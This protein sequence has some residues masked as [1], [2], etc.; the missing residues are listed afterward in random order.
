MAPKICQITCMHFNIRP[1]GDVAT[2]TSGIRLALPGCVVR[3][4]QNML[5]AILQQ[6]ASKRAAQG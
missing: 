6:T 5:D 3:L 1:A 4:L 2:K